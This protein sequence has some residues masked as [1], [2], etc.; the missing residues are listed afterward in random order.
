K[1]T[2]RLLALGRRQLIRPQLIDLNNVI[3]EVEGLLRSMAGE[4]IALRIERYA[5]LPVV[6]AEPLQMQEVLVN[7]VGNA[8]DAMPHGGSLTIATDCLRLDAEDPAYPGIDAGAYV[9]LSVIDSGSGLPIEI[10]SHLFE[11]FFTTKIPGKG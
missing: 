4:S 8:R 9:R 11:P 6:L 2:E 10:H 7:L 1:L 5:Q 3:D